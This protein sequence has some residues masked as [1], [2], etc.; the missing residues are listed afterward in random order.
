MQQHVIELN[1]EKYPDLL[2]LKQQINKL[3]D[4]YSDL[5]KDITEQAFG[6]I[7][8]LENKFF[9]LYKAKCPNT[10]Y[11]SGQDILY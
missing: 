5:N 10:N 1:I 9:A 11:E 3:W 6:E 8:N 4:R 2:E 7:I